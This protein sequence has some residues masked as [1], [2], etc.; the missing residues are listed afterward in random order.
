MSFYNR[1]GR[2][3]QTAVFEEEGY[4][5]WCSSLVKHEDIY[6][7]FYSRWKKEY[8]FEAWVSHSEI[9]VASSREL[10]GKFCF[11][12]VLFFKENSER[13]DRDCFHNP[14]VLSWQGKYYLYYMGNYGDGDFWSHRNHQRVG[15]A[16]AE[17][18][19]GEW[20]RPEEPVIDVSEDGF[21]CL[22]TSNP[23]VCV[24]PDGRIA[25]IYK[26]VGKEK[27]LPKGGPVVC[28]MAYAEHPE[29]PFAK[30][31]IPVMQNPNHPWSVE[32]P[33]LFVEKGRLFAIVK[34]FQGYFTGT[35]STS[36]ALFESPD[37]MD[38][39]PSEE[40]LAMDLCIP[41]EDGDIPVKRLERPQIYFED[42]APRALLL[43]VKPTEGDHSYAV[44]IPIV[45]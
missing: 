26:G 7:L 43:A 22:M 14:T 32:D 42:G 31:G 20:R 18:P 2:M 38:F 17:H 24:L 44:R 16:V 45:R 1:L 21:D 12:K 39:V 30:T 34:D 4:Y 36:L 35:G 25:M 13:W 8:G 11:E 41:T 5:V 19:L 9:A 23:S 3:T 40:P 28:G 15:V 27:P 37:G 6:Y 33:F 10:F 29:G